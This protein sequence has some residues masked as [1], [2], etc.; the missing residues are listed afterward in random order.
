[1]ASSSNGTSL[2]DRVE[3][4]PDAILPNA[5]R[6]NPASVGLFKDEFRAA[7][8]LRSSESV[9]IPEV[10]RTTHPPD[11]PPQGVAAAPAPTYVIPP[12]ARPPTA[13]KAV[14]PGAFSRA[15]ANLVNR[16]SPGGKDRPAEF[17][18]AL[19][20]PGQDWLLTRQ[21]R[22]LSPGKPRPPTEVRPTSALDLGLHSRITV[23]HAMAAGSAAACLEVPSGTSGNGANPGKPLMRSASPGANSSADTALTGGTG[24]RL[25]RIPSPGTYTADGAGVAGG[26]SGAL[27]AAAAAMVARTAGRPT[28]AV[29][30][31]LAAFIQD[32]GEDDRFANE[33]VVFSSSR[34]V[35]AYPPTRGQQGS[36]KGGPA[37][38]GNGAPAG[39]GGMASAALRPWTSKRAGLV[40]TTSDNAAAG[41][42]QHLRAA[43]ASLRKYAVPRNSTAISGVATTYARKP[44]APYTNDINTPTPS[45][46]IANNLSP[47]ARGLSPRTL[48]ILSPGGISPTALGPL[49]HPLWNEVDDA[50]VHDGVPEADGVHTAARKHMSYMPLELFDNIEY[51]LHTPEEWVELG[52]SEGGTPAETTVYHVAS[53]SHV[54]IDCRVIDWDEAERL[55]IVTFSNTANTGTKT[56]KV[57]RLNLRFKAEDPALFERR[58]TEAK[59]AREEAEQQLRL[60]FYIDSLALVEVLHTY[61]YAAA[62][63]RAALQ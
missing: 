26:P 35:S 39:G 46:R 3:P 61:N 23:A 53:D 33:A 60:F 51:D 17:V 5:L 42:V 36:S 48:E 29:P 54:W 10:L 8:R 49:P 28:S 18:E 11:L 41:A 32:V 37:G 7:Q 40:E 16:P 1:M 57:K 45:E 50:E 21:S 44:R 14:G 43:S 4:V 27:A 15:T 56:K 30:S 9:F 55:F 19:N 6:Q 31:E 25:P 58:L 59:A 52:A 12:T 63:Q 24:T 22:S 34:P 47:L 38:R 2:A 13:K 20:T 62:L